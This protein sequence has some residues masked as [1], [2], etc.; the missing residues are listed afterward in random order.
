[1]L[2]WFE[3]ADEVI[4]V[5]PMG[6]LFTISDKHVF[7]DIK[8]LAVPLAH[9][10]AVDDDVEWRDFMCAGATNLLIVK[11]NRNM[12]EVKRED[13]IKKRFQ[14]YYEF[15]TSID[16]KFKD[17]LYNHIHHQKTSHYFSVRTM[18]N[19]DQRMFYA[20]RKYISTVKMKSVEG[21]NKAYFDSEDEAERMKKW[22]HTDLSVF[23]SKVF[24]MAYLLKYKLYPLP[25]K[26]FE[27]FTIDGLLDFIKAS[28]SMRKWAK[29]EWV[30]LEDKIEKKADLEFRR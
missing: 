25:P 16:D 17:A 8:R 3:F 19:P 5:A 26:E 22:C 2:K 21:D 7:K 6:R 4:I 12:K 15:V 20:D 23:I 30:E 27:D 18:M 9:M 14:E 28:P 13:F 24:N 1:M 29:K 10:E 11:F